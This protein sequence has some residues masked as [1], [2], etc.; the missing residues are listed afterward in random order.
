MMGTVVVTSIGS[1]GRLPG[2]V[3]PRS[4]HNLCFALGSVIRKP[5]V[6]GDRI[7]IRE[8]LH[9]T[10]LFDHDVVDGAP[11]ARFMVNLVERLEGRAASEI[12]PREQGPTGPT[13]H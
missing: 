10:V 7:E 8:I 2:W 3:I 6:V 5:W 1:V 12:A 4:M 11:A 13:P 9:M